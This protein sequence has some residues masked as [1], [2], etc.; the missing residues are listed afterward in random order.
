M[1]FE[2]DSDFWVLEMKEKKRG[3]GD[4]CE[5]GWSL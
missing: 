3:C 5:N 1:S 2:I 4:Y